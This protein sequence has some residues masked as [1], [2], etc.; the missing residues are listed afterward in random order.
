MNSIFHY[1]YCCC[2]VT[3]LCP[4]FCNPM[5]CS[6]PG[7][8]AFT[9]S[10]SLLQFMSSVSVMPTN[11]LIFFCPLLLQGI[12]LTQGS[13]PSSLHCRSVLYHL[14]TRKAP[15]QSIQFSHSLMSNSL[16]PHRLQHTRLPCPSPTPRVCSNSCPL[17]Q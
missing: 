3:K 2:S 6:A 15:I 8:P 10:W 11:H 5:D 4:I 16:Q 17:S 9:I 13:N 12:F 1:S 14:A 7:S